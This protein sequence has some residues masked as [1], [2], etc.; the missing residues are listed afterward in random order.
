VLL[1]LAALLGCRDAGPSSPPTSSTGLLAGT[2]TLL[3]S[4]GPPDPAGL[5]IQLFAT[6]EELELRRPT[7]RAPLRRNALP[8]RSFDFSVSRVEPGEY[9]VIAC[10]EVGCGDYRDPGT[11]AWRRVRV[12]ASLTTWLTFGL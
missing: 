9:Y 7:F 2:V 8:G 4:D 10:C 12:R 6:T 3:G 5:D 1:I 11:G